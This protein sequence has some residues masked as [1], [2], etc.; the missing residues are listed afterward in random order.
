MEGPDDFPVPGSR[1]FL[2]LGYISA[3]GFCA[4]SLNTFNTSI[5]C[6]DPKWRVERS[7]GAR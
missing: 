1:S 6:V 4:R 2:S 3:L 7:E 5:L